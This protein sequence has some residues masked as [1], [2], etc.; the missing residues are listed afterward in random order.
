MALLRA[1][2]A[3]STGFP[4]PQQNPI[5][6]GLFGCFALFLAAAKNEAGRAPGPA[7]SFQDCNED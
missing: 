5:N 1:A 6:K 2:W 4:S 7:G 3:F